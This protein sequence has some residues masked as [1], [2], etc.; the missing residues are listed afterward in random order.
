MLKRFASISFGLA[1]LAFLASPASARHG[2]P[3]PVHHHRGRGGNTITP[4]TG[5]VAHDKNGDHGKNRGNDGANDK[6]DD[7]GNDGPNHK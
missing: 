5:G 3:E 2:G 6:N 4:S 1:A 7:H